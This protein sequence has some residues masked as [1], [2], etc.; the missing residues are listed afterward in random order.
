MYYLI[1]SYSPFGLNYK[2]FPTREYEEK[3]DLIS[4]TLQS[5]MY[6]IIIFFMYY[7]FYYRYGDIF[8]ITEVAQEKEKKQKVY[9]HQIVFILI[10]GCISYGICFNNWIKI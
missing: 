4:D 7:I 2:L 6:Y 10:L 8:L 9:F 1:F 5:Q 3:V